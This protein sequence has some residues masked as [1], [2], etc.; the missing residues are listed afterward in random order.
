[1]LTLLLTF[2][3]LWGCIFIVLRSTRLKSK[4]TKKAII[5]FASALTCII[6]YLLLAIVIRPSGPFEPLATIDYSFDKPG[7]TE[8][9]F[10]PKFFRNHEIA[11]I[12]SK[13]FPSNERFTWK[14]HVQ[15][16]RFGIKLDDHELR[17]NSR[18]YVERSQE[19]CTDISFGWIR[20]LDLIPGKT[21]VRITVEE[22]DFKGDTYSRFLKVAIR[23]SPII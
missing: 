6:V 9:I 18:T 15:V 19:N 12:S 20:T 11:I 7:T 3:G 21:I 13:P 8:L 17:E 5:S 4:L 10:I 2:L 1:M 22:G 14:A 16:Y 23:P